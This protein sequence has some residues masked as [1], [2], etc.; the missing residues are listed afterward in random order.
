MTRFFTIAFAALGGWV[1]WKLGI[2]VGVLTAYF[3]SVF[4]TAGGL[5]VG[6]RVAETLLE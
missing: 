3:S 6:R 1:G 2:S 4:G 5:V